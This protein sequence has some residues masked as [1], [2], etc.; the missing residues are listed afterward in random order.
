MT[1]EEENDYIANTGVESDFKFSGFYDDGFFEGSVNSDYK[2]PGV[3]HFE[4]SSA[5]AI[6]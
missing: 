6:C 4:R 2:Q 3:G 5:G 1:I